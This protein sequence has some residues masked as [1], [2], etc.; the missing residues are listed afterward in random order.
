MLELLCCAHPSG[1]PLLQQGDEGNWDFEAVQ[2][3]TPR[4]EVR[5]EALQT[6]M[7]SNKQA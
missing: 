4:D 5:I 1:I 7:H 3:M 2:D 6:C